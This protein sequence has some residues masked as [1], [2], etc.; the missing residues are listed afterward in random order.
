MLAESCIICTQIIHMY[1]TFETHS[2][3]Y[4]QTCSEVCIGCSV[5]Q[6]MRTLITLCLTALLATAG[7]NILQ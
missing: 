2:L 7:E 5:E 1:S 6:R 3:Y 4:L